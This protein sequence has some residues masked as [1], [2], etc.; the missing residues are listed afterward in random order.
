MTTDDRVTITR[1][2]AHSEHKVSVDG[3]LWC[4][5]AAPHVMLGKNSRGPDW[6]ESQR[7]AEIIAAGPHDGLAIAEALLA[8]GKSAI[9]EVNGLESQLLG[10]G[11]AIGDQAA[12]N[13]YGITV[14][15]A[16]GQ[17]KVTATQAK[18]GGAVN[19]VL[20]VDGKVLQTVLVDLKRSQ[21][22]RLN[23]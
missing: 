22:G 5:V 15:Q 13:T 4:I 9:N 1:N 19:V 14:S 6:A 8:G 16:S 11:L 12:Q 20:T 17:P 2:S 18:A 23:F 10:T 21:G 3:E 7:R